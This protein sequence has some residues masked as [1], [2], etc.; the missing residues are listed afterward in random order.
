[1]ASQADYFA[2]V[3][4]TSREMYHTA[5]A[6]IVIDTLVFGLFL[7][8]MYRQRKRQRN[9]NEIG[10]YFLMSVAYISVL[11][12]ALVGVLLVKIGGVGRHVAFWESTD[13]DTFTKFLQLQ[14]GI[15]II[16]MASITAPKI[17]ILTLYLKI[18]T[19]R[20]A[21][22]LTWIMGVI[23]VMFLLS[24]LVLALALCKP[25]EYKWNKTIHGKCGDIMAGYR[26]ISIPS[27]ITDF[28]ILIIP[29]PTIWKLRV[30]TYKKVGVLIT[31]LTGS[32]GFIT[33]IVRCL[34]FYT[35]N[36]FSDPTWLAGKT[37][38][39]TIIESSAYFICAC[40]PRLRPLLQLFLEKTGVIS[41]VANTWGTFTNKSKGTHD[42]S[43]HD[44]SNENRGSRPG[45]NKVGF[46][47][48]D[49]LG[50]VSSNERTQC[51]GEDEFN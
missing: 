48:M 9:K 3:N 6:F 10:I 19:D 49:E 15:E 8:S 18:F 16:Y 29:I 7:A 17:A 21:R 39:W 14:T 35:S 30:D 23:L 32:L 12:N 22:Q 50:L 34:T 40:L 5:M 44:M 1:M 2:E 24:G 36:L 46:V 11:G 43:A 47:E 4:P 41:V 27:I 28:F 42:G 20:L 51:S 26:W 38:T 37:M 31:F 25:Y 13:P 33:A 45:D